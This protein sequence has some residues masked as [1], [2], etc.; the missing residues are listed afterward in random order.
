MKITTIPVGILQAN[1]YILNKDNKIIIIDP[2]DEYA[3]IKQ[4]IQDKEIVKIL[5]THH[6]PDHIGALNHFA[7][8]LIL[9]HP[10]A[11][12]YTF[13]PFSFDVITTKGHTEDS[14]TYYFKNENTMFTGDFLFKNSIGRTDMPTGNI[15]DM[16]YSLNKIKTY[17]DDT[18]IYPGHGPSTTLKHEKE[19]N[20][21]LK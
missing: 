4:Y 15:S 17:P 20:Y 8:H 11:Q 10:K 7:S 6:H 12:T 19:T 16:Q 9:K 14:V 21:F 5:I 13:G 18:I 2:G 3:K 1:C